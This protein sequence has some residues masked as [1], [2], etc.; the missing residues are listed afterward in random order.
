MSC[1]HFTALSHFGGLN[2]EYATADLHSVSS[3]Q[4]LRVGE[5]YASITGNAYFTVSYDTRCDTSVNVHFTL[6]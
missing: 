1:L 5:L 3:Q 2:I 4:H 6:I